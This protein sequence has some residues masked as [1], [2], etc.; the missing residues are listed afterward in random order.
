MK[1][2]LLLKLLLLM[3]CAEEV[4]P[5]NSLGF[6]RNWGSVKEFYKKI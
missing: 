1:S 3:H 2:Q 6:Q 4:V 5:E